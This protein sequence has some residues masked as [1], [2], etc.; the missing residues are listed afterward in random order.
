MQRWR[1]L[2]LYLCL[3]MMC[4]ATVEVK[5]LTSGPLGL[6]RIVDPCDRPLYPAYPWA[7]G[8]FLGPRLCGC[9]LSSH[10]LP[11]VTNGQGRTNEVRAAALGDLC[12]SA[13]QIAFWRRD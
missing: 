2:D 8:A 12:P 5:D 6:L 4:P 13:A 1:R 7:P 9:S 3:S 11:G 10:H